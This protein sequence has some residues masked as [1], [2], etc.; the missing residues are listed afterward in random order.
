MVNEENIAN[1]ELLTLAALAAKFNVWTIEHVN[2]ESIFFE[3]G[4]HLFVKI[5]NPITDNGDAFELAVKLNIRTCPHQHGGKES[6]TAGSTTLAI[7]DDACK[8]MRKAIVIEA[9][10]L[11]KNRN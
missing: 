4:G 10:R 8:A 6:V 2:N 5:W 3:R 1:S 7:D 11:G 9:A